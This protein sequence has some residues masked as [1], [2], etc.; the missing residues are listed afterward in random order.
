MHRNGITAPSGLRAWIAACALACVAAA[1]PAQAKTA[2]A[3]A[4]A[5]SATLDR[6]QKSGKLRLGYRTD[7]RPFSFKDEQGQPAGYSVALCQTVADAIK[8]GTGLSTLNVEWVPLAMADHFTAVAQGQVDL[9]C[10]A[11]TQTLQ[12]MEEVGFSI[13][14]FPGGIG[15]L[16]RADASARLKDIL[17]GRPDTDPHW[18]A[19]AGALVQAQT[20]TVVG[21]TTAKTW[22]DGKL[23]SFRLTASV[24][25]VSGYDEGIQAVVDRKANVFFGDRAILLDAVQRHASAGD[26]FVIDR[27]F[28]YEKISL[29]LPRND[30]GFAVVVDRALSKFYM[31]PQFTAQYTKWFG[32]PRAGASNFFRWIVLPE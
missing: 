30:D 19:S 28:T 26:L 5:K 13:P 14:I 20:F 15:A 2:A 4:A 7:A 1:L 10:G 21:G 29:T 6:I 27:D 25:P 12:R 9:F 16:V 8:A 22:L 24:Q 32:T 3:P 17:S 18:R 31:S 23:N 11:D